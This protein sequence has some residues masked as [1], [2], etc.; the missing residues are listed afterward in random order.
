M[1]SEGDFLAH[2][3]SLG[4]VRNGGNDSMTSHSRLAYE[5]QAWNGPYE[6]H[7]S[8]E[9]SRRGQSR[10]HDSSLQSPVHGQSRANNVFWRDGFQ[11]GASADQDL[12]MGLDRHV[13]GVHVPVPSLSRDQSPPPAD[14]AWPTRSLPTSPPRNSTVKV[15]VFP[16]GLEP[17]QRAFESIQTEL[18]VQSR[19]YDDNQNRLA[20][21]E[22][23]LSRITRLT[24]ETEE[25]YVAERQQ[26]HN[27]I[28]HLTRRTEDVILTCES[29]RNMQENAIVRVDNLDSNAV[30][31][32]LLVRAEGELQAEVEQLKAII[33][34]RFE[35]LGHA[36]RRADALERVLEENT[37]LR[38]EIAQL[39]KTHERRDLEVAGLQGQLDAL[40]R[41]VKERLPIEGPPIEPQYDRITIEAPN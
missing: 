10:A 21:T 11:T 20:K 12:R 23:D 27:S 15:P 22:A 29:L 36:L 2:S 25:L 3:R 26:K 18:L 28:T 13:R 24:A 30:G 35:V 14:L 40:T 9:W 17:V 34:E 6:V 1:S 41:L 31:G 8:Q 19:R 39:R 16:S 33:R 4:A 5:V 7:S 32:H 37:K 38:Q